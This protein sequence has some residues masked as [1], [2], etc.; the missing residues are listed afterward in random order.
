MTLAADEISIDGKT[1]KL[2]KFRMSQLRKVAKLTTDGT[3]MEEL[4]FIVLEMALANATPPLEGDAADPP[5]S[6]D[7]MRDALEKVM[8]AA[9]LKLT[10]RPGDVPAGEAA[11]PATGA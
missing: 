10:E 5:M 2:G 4:P 8:V 9:G 1:H 3:P 11:A 7:E 6:A